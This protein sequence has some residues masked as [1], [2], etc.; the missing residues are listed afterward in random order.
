MTITAQL[1]DGRT[2]EFP[3]GTDPAVIQATVKRVIG[4]AP[5][6]AAPDPMAGMPGWQRSLVGIGAEMTDWG[7]ALRQAGARPANALGL[8]SDEKMAAINA[9]DA[10]KRDV[11]KRLDSDI[12][13]NV[14]R[15]TAMAVP[16]LGVTTA[17]ARGAGALGTVLGAL[18]P[19]ENEQ[20]RVLSMLTSGALGAA[21]Q[22]LGNRI[23]GWMTGKGKAPA[24]SPDDVKIVQDAQRRGY[25][26]RPAQITDSPTMR[27]VETQLASQPGSSGAMASSRAAQHERFNADLFRTMGEP[28]RASIAPGTMDDIQANFTA[29]YGKATEGVSLKQDAA[30]IDDLTGVMEQYQRNLLPDQ[31]AIVSQYVNDI[32]DTFDG[33][34]YQTWRSRIGTRAAG[35][36]DSEL[37][38]AL[39]GV[40]KALDDAFDRQAPAGAKRAMESTRGEYRNFKTLEPLIAKAEA[41]GD[42][43][44]PMNVAQRVA[45]AKNLGGELAD[46]GRIGRV[47]GK[48]GPNS[49]TAQNLWAQRL[50]T[51]SLPAAGAGAGYYVGGTPEAAMAGGASALAGSLLLPKAASGVYLSKALRG[52]TQRAAEKGA[53]KALN[54]S[55]L[56]LALR[57]I[58]GDDELLIEALTRGG[59]LGLPAL[60]GG[61]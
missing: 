47:I 52:M 41:R 56:A 16:G 58:G 39:K 23:A 8:L 51:G 21:G 1:A 33:K 20:Q 3:D 55:A 18:V 36:Q 35:T 28:P 37:K 7:T 27:A 45:S 5:A 54:P 43:I 19:T 60:S 49:G 12:G 32:P 17:T 61:E 29:K 44:S 26:L 57:K 50:V 34:A 4:A 48:E 11:D 25:N 30:L 10:A 13:A 6:E 24:L 59:A 15:F 22:A 14:G 46:L 53:S 38:G 9:E 2:L 42:D 31:R 40:Q